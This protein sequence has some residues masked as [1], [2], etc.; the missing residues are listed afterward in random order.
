MTLPHWKY[1]GNVYRKV[2]IYG[3]RVN[4]HQAVAERALGRRLP[5]GAQVHHVDENPRN[6]AN[7]NLVICQDMAY[8][9]LLHMRAN[10]L[11]AGGNPNTD[12]FCHKCRTAKPQDKFGRNCGHFN[13]RTSRCLVC[14]SADQLQRSARKRA[15]AA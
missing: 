5:K 7:T 4:L 15:E 14:L 10:V 1:H 12:L 11:R 8:H 3:R 6:N 2:T 9:K 13:G